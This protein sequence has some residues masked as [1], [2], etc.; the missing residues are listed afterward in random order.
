MRRRGKSQ[1]SR[2][3]TRPKKKLRGSKNNRNFNKESTK[4]EDLEGNGKNFLY[5]F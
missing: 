5:E 2:L 1:W 4:N 3:T